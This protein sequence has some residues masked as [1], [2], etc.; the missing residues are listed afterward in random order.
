MKINN[1]SIQACHTIKDCFLVAQLHKENISKG[2]LKELGVVPL[3]FLY[4]AIKKCKLSQLIVAKDDNGAVVGFVSIALDLPSLYRFFL[5]RYGVIVGIFALPKLIKL[6]RIKKVLNIFRYGKEKPQK[7]INNVSAE[8]LSIVVD[9]DWRGTGVADRLFN[10]LVK[11]V[12]VQ[13]KEKAFKIIVGES[14]TPAQKFYE[15]MGAVKEGEVSIHDN[16]KSFMYVKNT[17][18]C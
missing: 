10:Q 16:Q 15:K 14:L 6:S 18:S 9:S 8:L 12:K 4:R 17:E 5:I 13:T 3:F 7:K 2:F 1:I 11:I